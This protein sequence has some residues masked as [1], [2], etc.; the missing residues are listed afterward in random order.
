MQ[1]CIY[2]V[3]Y[4]DE[5]SFLVGEDC[6]VENG[7]DKINEEFDGDAGD[8]QFVLILHF[9]SLLLLQQLFEFVVALEGNEGDDEQHEH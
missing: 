8:E 9:N 5:A 7:E 1:C 6:V 3:L 2:C 4:A